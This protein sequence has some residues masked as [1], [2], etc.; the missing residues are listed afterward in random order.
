MFHALLQISF[1]IYRLN[2][3]VY[4]TPDYFR[5]NFIISIIL[6]LRHSGCPGCDAAWQGSQFTALTLGGLGGL[7]R[8][9]C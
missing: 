5:K 9:I 6:F 2:N 4:V 1:Y 3:R 7:Y 8:A